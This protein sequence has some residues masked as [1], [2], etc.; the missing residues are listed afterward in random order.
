MIRENTLECPPPQLSLQQVKQIAADYYSLEGEFE[1]LA[2]ERDL[3]FKVLTSGNAA[4]VLKISNAAEDLQ[5]VDC[6]N[7]VLRH[8]EAVVPDLPIPR[9]RPNKAGSLL[10]QVNIE[11]ME[12][13]IRLLTFLPGVLFTD[14]TQSSSLT[15]SV[16]HFL[17][18]MDKALQSVGHPAAHKKFWWDVRQA[19]FIEEYCS[20]I[21]AEADRALVKHF[22]TRFKNH[23]QAQLPF[24]RSQVI[25]NDA[26]DHNLLVDPED[27]RK[28]C[29]LIDFGDLTFTYRINEIAVALAYSLMQQD[30][31]LTGATELIAAYHQENALEATELAVLYDLVAIR[32]CTSVVISSW[33][34]KQYPDNEYL[35]VSQQPALALLKKWQGINPHI[36]HFNFR[37]ACGFE[38]VPD[39]STIMEYLRSSSTEFAPVLGYDLAKA[40]KRVLSFQADS[41]DLLE[42]EKAGS[43]AAY[44]DLLWQRMQADGIDVYVGCYL[45]DRTVYKGDGFVSPESIDRRTVHTGID[46]F[47]KAGTPVYA[48]LDGKVFSVQNNAIRLDYGPT[49]ILEHRV[50]N[51]ELCFYTL[52]G[53]LSMET[54]EHLQVSQEIKRGDC[55]A[56][57]G[58]FP[59]NGDWVPHL[60]FQVMTHML[61]MRGNF[62]GVAAKSQLKVWEKI[63]LD[64]NLILGIPEETFKQQGR[65]TTELLAARYQNLGPSLSVSY[66]KPLKI[67]RGKGVYLYDDSGRAYLDCVNNISHVG[68]CHPHVVEA[69]SKQAT[70]LNT[71]TRYLH[72]TIVEYAERLTNYF[73][74]PLNV[75]YFVCTGSEA[76]E[77]ALRLAKTYSQQRDVITVDAAYHGN[78][79]GLID[80]SAYKNQGPGG[81][82][83]GEYVSTVPLPDTY[84]GEIKADAANPGEQYARFVQQAIEQL[85]A[86]KRKPAAF[87]CES[88]PGCGGQIV[89]PGGYLK[90]AYA[91]V[92]AFGGVCIA[93][94]VQVGFGRMGDTF[95]GFELQDVVP[96]IVTLGKPIGNGHP[97]A[98]VI[99]TREIAEAFN[100]GMEYFNSFGGN[101]VSCAVGMA[102]LDVI[103]QEHLQTNAKLVG[104]YLKQEL[105][106]LQAQYPII[107][108]V[109][110]H[111]LYLGAELISD[112]Q[113][114]EPASKEAEIITNRMRDSGVLLSTDGPL[115]N[116]LKIKPPMVINGKNVDYMMERL[117]KCLEM[118]Q[119]N[120]LS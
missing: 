35:L 49:V 15:S 98:A 28:V 76:N 113:N 22:Y 6:E 105:R 53:H 18:R 45:E 11:G 58:D 32:L 95:W 84:R 119:N 82:G 27:H 25:H 21:E 8:L 12:Y 69:L 81:R 5:V 60:H 115:H 56:W 99:T 65:G 48:P 37:A 107:G 85:A 72:D 112:S 108:D 59:D 2:S 88:L 1:S 91:H 75:V 54:L 13:A 97:L 70:R 36:A 4:F 43:V 61:G 7:Q 46:L 34:A 96:D 9:L 94:E 39:V 79:A 19:D 90:S 10:S 111:G 17:G 44:T 66:K 89:L 14:A 80:I 68:H 114:L 93:D 55:I 106:N 42:A 40:R 117:R 100:N 52:Y 78:T 41:E 50:P 74:D 51:I 86:K 3:N 103:E 64:P 23:T 102:V 29:G 31:L 33:R 116:V 38:A 120:S 30:D 87:I 20:H 24:L 110:G 118:V 109:R 71:N 77:L 57:F 16:G 47:A 83:P 104:D 73:P 63:C 67:V 62:P 92:R 26:N 101:P